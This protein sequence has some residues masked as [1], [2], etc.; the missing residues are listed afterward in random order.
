MIN[1]SGQVNP[2]LCYSSDCH[3]RASLQSSRR[4]N[5]CSDQDCSEE[6]ALGEESKLMP[7]RRKRQQSRRGAKGR[8]RSRRAGQRRGRRGVGRSRVRVV[9]GRVAVRVGGFS[10]LQHLGASQLI[11]FVPLNKIK[12]AAKRLL[13]KPQGKK[14][15]RRRRK[16]RK[17]KH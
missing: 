1:S 12:S 7:A 10:G 16:Q 14:Q 13:G 6:G 15:K 5:K 2:I 8:R 11:R 3:Q 9:R 4:L 17:P